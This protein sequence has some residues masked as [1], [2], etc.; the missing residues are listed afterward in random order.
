MDENPFKIQEGSIR[1]SKVGGFIAG[2]HSGDHVDFDSFGKFERLGKFFS[3]KK[4]RILFLVFFSLIFILF[5][6][7]FYLQG[8]EGDYYRG[9]AEGNR[10]RSDVI[11][12]NRGLMYDR[13]GQA[14]VKNVSYFFLYIKPDLMPE[15]DLLRL[16][17]TDDLAE[18]LELERSD[19]DQRLTE[20][21]AK[22]DKALVYENLPY[23]LAIRLMIMSEKYPAIE[24]THE[25]RREYD[26]DYGLAHTMG[27]LGEVSEEDVENGYNYHDRIGK[28]GLEYVYQDTMKGKN[29]IRQVEVDALFREKSII[30]MT[31][32]IE[33]KDIVLTIDAKAQEKL[34]EIMNDVS[35]RF[36]KPKMA[37]VILDPK[38]GGVLAMASLP[39]YNNNIFTTI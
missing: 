31:E 14:L 35:E 36:D 2:K 19:L 34:F 5:V 38:D 22:G 27:Y 20:G 4:V 25:P 12:A 39:S 32:P 17:F 6:R 23:D 33:G 30:S 16:D 24:V 18:L 8:L 28:T 3:E 1:D 9:V 37:A 29:G 13:F 11:R 7:A 26:T 15:D 21:S 10:I